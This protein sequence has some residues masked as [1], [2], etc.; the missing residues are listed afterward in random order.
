MSFSLHFKTKI[1]IQ[2]AMLLQQKVSPFNFSYG[3]NF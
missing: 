1:N 3:I 2:K